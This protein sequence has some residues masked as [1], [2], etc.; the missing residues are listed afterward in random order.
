MF[1]VTSGR[2]WV[3][4]GGET[5]EVRQGDV[6]YVPAGVEHQTVAASD[7]ALEYLL[8]NA[9]LSD[10]KEG[11]ATFAEHIEQVKALR[12]AQAEAGWRGADE[13]P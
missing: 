7:E 9:F 4:V 3:S 10:E 13:R 1:L 6:V 5:R 11:H 8:Y 2:G 12:R